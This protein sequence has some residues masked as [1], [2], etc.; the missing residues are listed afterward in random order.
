MILGENVSNVY[1]KGKEIN[2]VYSYGKL[3]WEKN[4]GEID[5]SR[6]YFTVKANEDNVKIA[7]VGS[8]N[9][10]VNY[11]YKLNDS[12]WETSNEIFVLNEGDILSLASVSTDNESV[13]KIVA[14]K[15]FDV[16]GNIMSL[17]YGDKFIGKKELPHTLQN[18]F[19]GTKIQN[20]ENLVLPTTTLTPLCYYRMFYECPLLTAPKILPATTLADYCYKEMFAYCEYLTT[21]PELP[22]T[23]LA[24]QCYCRMFSWCHHM[25]VAPELPATTLAPQCYYE[26]FNYCLIRKAP[27]IL[28]ATT[29]TEHC[30]FRMFYECPYLTTPPEL[31]AT[32]LAKSCYYEMF[33]YC[34]RLT[35]APELPATTLADYCY[36]GMFWECTKLTVAPELPATT[37]VEGCYNKMFAFCGRIH[38]LK[39]YATGSVISLSD[40]ISNWLYYTGMYNEDDEEWKVGTLE[41]YESYANSLSK[42]TPNWWDVKY[43][44]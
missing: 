41:C 5:Y 13:Y 44:V 1:S 2:K 17:F 27:K 19:E 20:A 36:S 35:Y 30:Y 4:S 10:V 37:L 43:I 15:T 18:F 7:L 32:T 6:K 11:K 28:P 14:A 3:V 33:A 39:C 38:Y 21:P 34:V 31:P 42:Y 24:L 40:C 25:H 23:T 12:N 29:L 8:D 9:L 26:M 16:S 22:A